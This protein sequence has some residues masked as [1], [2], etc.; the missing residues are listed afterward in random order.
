M[1]FFYELIHANYEGEKNLK[2]RV[3]ARLATIEQIETNYWVIS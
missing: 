3:K 1:K 2:I